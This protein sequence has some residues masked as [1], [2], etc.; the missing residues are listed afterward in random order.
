MNTSAMFEG[1]FWTKRYLE[2]WKTILL[3]TS[4][5]RFDPLD[6]DAREIVGAVFIAL[7]QA[8]QECQRTDDPIQRGR[9]HFP[10]FNVTFRRI[11][12]MNSI[13]YDAMNWPIPSKKCVTH[14][15]TILNRLFDMINK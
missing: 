5:V 7:S 14:S 12:D 1:R 10:N 4:G 13:A 9:K 11:M 2:K 3:E 15:N 8:W 6:D